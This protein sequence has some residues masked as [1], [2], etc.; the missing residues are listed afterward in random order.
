M[1]TSRHVTKA[2]RRYRLG[3]TG[4]IM[5]VLTTEAVKNLDG[6]SDD[7]DDEEEE[8]EDEFGDVCV[9]ILTNALP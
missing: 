6:V 7:D 2:R 8:G 3:T 1:E 9:E 4:N 5:R